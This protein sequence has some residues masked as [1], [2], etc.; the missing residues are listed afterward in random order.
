MTEK[1]KTV[2]DLIE[3]AEKYVDL[4][5]Q[6]LIKTDQAQKVLGEAGAQVKN[7]LWLSEN[8][9]PRFLVHF[10]FPN[11]EPADQELLSTLL[12]AVEEIKAAF[13]IR[14]AEWDGPR[15]LELERVMTQLEKTYMR[16]IE[17]TQ[18]IPITEM[19]RL[20]IRKLTRFQ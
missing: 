11:L 13:V 18:K 2:Q 6:N 5:S 7:K 12:V 1:Q 17:C 9:R 8:L 16:G 15:K 3:Q 14:P 10:L 4:A 19:Q 20:I